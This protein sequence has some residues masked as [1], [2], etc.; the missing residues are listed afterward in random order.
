MKRI[1]HVTGLVKIRYKDVRV[2]VVK[3]LSKKL[4]QLK[5]DDRIQEL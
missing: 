5:T 4:I 2:F 1:N 3:E